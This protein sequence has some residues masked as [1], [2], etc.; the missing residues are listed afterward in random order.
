MP[1]SNFQPI[2][3]LDLSFW[4]KFNDTADPDELA[5]N[6]S[7]STLFAKTGHVLFN[8]RRVKINKN[9]LINT[10]V[11]EQN[12]FLED[13]LCEAGVAAHINYKY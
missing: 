5:S 3:L 8:K 10:T 4:Y 13:P 1:T 2:R 12:L 7:G 11:S 6:W 9:K